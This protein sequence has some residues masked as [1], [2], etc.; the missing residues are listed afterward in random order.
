[1]SAK[2]HETLLNPALIP[3]L[4][5]AIRRAV[6]PDDVL[7]PAR[8]LPS[9]EEVVEIKREC[10]RAIVDMLPG[11]LR[12]HYFATKDTAL[13]QAEVEDMLDVFSDDYINKHLV[14]AAL[15]MIVVRL[16]PELATAHIG[17]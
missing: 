15:E 5:Q 17:D 16:F 8:Q 1:M 2:V 12:T 7:G 4:L 13:M 10:G 3:P 11:L 14:V 9:Y 6:F